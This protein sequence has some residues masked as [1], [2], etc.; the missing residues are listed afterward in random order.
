MSNI[1]ID[2]T[3]TALVVIDLQKGI[4]GRQTAPYASDIVVKN[5]ASLA[6]AFRENGMPVFLVR[7][8]PSS[9]GKYA[10]RPIADVTMPAQTPP[11]GWAEIV[12]EMGSKESIRSTFLFHTELDSE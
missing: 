7:V 12:S 4:V 8:N 10:L 11:P 2:K 5:A 9:D 6:A 1:S 3:K